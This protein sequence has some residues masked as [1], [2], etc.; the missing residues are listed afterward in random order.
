MTNGKKFLE[1][2]SLTMNEIIPINVKQNEPE[3]LRLLAAM[4]FL[5][6]RAKILRSFRVCITVM[7]PIVSILSL[8]YFPNFKGYL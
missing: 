2:S 3:S 8:N 1:V 5:Y 4:R 7:L 6:G